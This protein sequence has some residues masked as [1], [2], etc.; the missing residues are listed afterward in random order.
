[1]FNF[2]ACTSFIDLK[3]GMSLDPG[4]LLC[5]T[6]LRFACSSLSTLGNVSSKEYVK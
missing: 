5:F 6:T 4:V 1:M 3:V 2:I